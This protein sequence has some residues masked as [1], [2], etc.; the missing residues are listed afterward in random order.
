MEMHHVVDVV[1]V[2]S[3]T[4]CVTAVISMSLHELPKTPPMLLL[5]SLDGFRH[6]YLDMFNENETANFQYFI[7][8]GVKAKHV[9]NVFPSVTFPNHMTLLTG[10]Y[11]ETHGV[12]H[13]NFYDPKLND[14][15]FMH[16]F[17]QNLEPKW[18]D[19]GAEPIWVT[20]QKSGLERKSGSLM[21]PGGLTT[22]K[23]IQP[24]V[25]SH[26]YLYNSTQQI[27]YRQRIDYIIKWFTDKKEPINLGLLYFPEPDEVG[28]Q[29]G[30]ASKEVKEEILKIDAA[31]GHL[32]T[33]L[34]AH[35]LLDKMNIILT[36]DH[37]M[38]EVGKSFINLDEYLKPDTYTTPINLSLGYNMVIPELVPKKGIYVM[39]LINVYF[40]LSKIWV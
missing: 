39:I 17:Y 23:C 28:H 10:V 13:N 9:I 29:Y 22:V 27:S 36:A 15:F 30:P 3:L 34:D 11:P 38:T 16:T 37:G 8:N 6:D 33:E 35:G 7:K 24:K 4:F 14:T 19:N 21:W 32:R 2:V 40:V 18:F 26:T 20:N 25:L 12:T 5:V 31:L 1:V